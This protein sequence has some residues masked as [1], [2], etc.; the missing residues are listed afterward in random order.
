LSTLLRAGRLTLSVF[1]LVLATLLAPPVDGEPLSSSPRSFTELP[2]A[3]VFVAWTTG[4][5]E[6]SPDHTSLFRTDGSAAGTAE[7]RLCSSF[8]DPRAVI[9]TSSGQ[10]AFVTAYDQD[11]SW[12]IWRTDGTQAGTRQLTAVPFYSLP[13]DSHGVTWAAGLGRFFF[14]AEELGGWTVWAS[15]GTAPGT[16]RVVTLPAA[17]TAPFG[18]VEHDGAVYFFVS[19]AEPNLGSYQLW[20]SGGTSATT[21]QVTVVAAHLF[22][23]DLGPATSLPDGLIFAANDPGTGEKRLWRTDGTAGGTGL[24]AAFGG[25]LDHTPR[26]AGVNGLG[27]FWGSDASG[28]QLW[29]T[30]GSEAGTRRLTSIAPFGNFRAGAWDPFPWKDGIVFSAE[31]A[32]HGFE[33]WASD[34]TPEGTGVLLDRCAGPCWAGEGT[35]AFGTTGDRI[36]F[37]DE[38]GHLWE[39]DG[40]PSGSR[41]VASVIVSIPSHVVPPLVFAGD[42][43]YFRGVESQQLIEQVWALERS[44]GELRQLTDFGG[45]PLRFGFDWSSGTLGERLLF[46]ADDGTSGLEPWVSDGTAAGTHMITDLATGGDGSPSCF[47]TDLALCLQGNRFRVEVSWKDQHNDG[48]GLGRAVPASGSDVSGYFWF[49]APDN[50]ELIVKVL[51]GTS[52][53]GFHWTFYGALTDVEYEIVVTDTVTGHHRTYHNPPGEICGEGDTASLPGSG[54]T[55]AAWSGTT[56]GGSLALPT[57]SADGIDGVVAAAHP[58][59]ACVPD[60]ETLCLLDGR[61]RVRVDWQDQHNDGAGSG[62]AIPFTDISGFFWFFTPDNVE[63]VV[64]ALDARVIDGHFWFF[65]GAL[66][67]VGYTI[68]VEDLVDGHRSQQYVNPPGEICGRGDTAAFSG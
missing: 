31:D 15:D 4:H 16:Q 30:D 49:F 29:L 36:Y 64:K 59:Q 2:A 25:T 10:L 6:P 41:E 57:G 1:V 54:A 52:L 67:D 13:P 22:P 8:C 17:Q 9:V 12:H 14:V 26:V 51:D 11:H 20:R 50:I 19:A 47:P 68:T 27:W 66:S 5:P 23:G 21:T 39:T 33:L 46:A 38:D 55:A 56:R 60:A 34:G 48:A 7:L 18:L 42:L 45:F 53:N 63:L 58:A 65:Y 62:G 35:I 28:R 44:T 61:F 3:S 43:I 37:R 24:V 40:T 32:A